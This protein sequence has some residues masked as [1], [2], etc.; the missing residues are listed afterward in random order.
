M[1]VT[2]TSIMPARTGGLVWF[3]FDA[4]SCDSIEAIHEEL[5][6]HGIIRGVRIDTAIS[7]GARRVTR[8]TPCILGVGLI[9]AITPLDVEILCE[10]GE[11]LA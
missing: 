6:G 8:R 9:G 3:A 4:P 11:V 7:L 1:N 10:D 5:K 2:V